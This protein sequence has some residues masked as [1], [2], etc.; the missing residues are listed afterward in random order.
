M[1]NWLDQVLE[2]RPY[3]VLQV[4]VTLIASLVFI[5]IGCAQTTAGFLAGSVVYPRAYLFQNRL[6]FDFMKIAL[7]LMRNRG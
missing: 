2:D 6:L 7:T 3:A 1:D 5:S 4:I